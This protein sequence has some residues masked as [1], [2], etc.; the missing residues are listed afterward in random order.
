M[1]A[2]GVKAADILRKDFNIQ[3]RVLQMAS[4]KPIDRDAIIKSAQETGYIITV[5]EHNVLGGLGSAVSEIVAEE[6]R[7][8][9]VR[10]GID[11]HFC[12]V[13]SAKC[14]AEKEGLTAQN[15]IKQTIKLLKNEEKRPE[16]P[17]SDISRGGSQR[18]P[19][20]NIKFLGGKPLIAYT[21]ECAKKS[22][23][24]NRI[25]VS[26]DSDKISKV[27]QGCG[28]EVPFRRPANISK[29]DSSEFD[30]FMHALEW[31]KNKEG[32]VPD[33]IVKLFPTSPFRKTATVDKAIELLLKILQLIHCARCVYARSILIKCGV[34]IK[35]QAA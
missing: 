2:E 10:I 5:E 35:R 21:I 14:L 3:A 13:G 16:D 30:A 8:K 33:L 34:S 4:V 15:I 12:G 32:Y 29:S 19:R 24:I 27:A 22:K 20:K 18:I 6:A 23:Y 17:L 11:D 26:T 25:I 1:M 28:A 7:A 9:V 31:L